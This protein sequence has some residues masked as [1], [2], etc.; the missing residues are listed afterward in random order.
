MESHEQRWLRLAARSRKTLIT[1]P[2]TT[3]TPLMSRR[4]KIHD[5]IIGVLLIA[6]TGLSIAVDPRFMWLAGITGMIMLS[7]SFTGF[8][9]VHYAVRR[10]L[11]DPTDQTAV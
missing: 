9:P 1:I 8:C 5:G 11:P 2:M 6:T 10:A 3:K 7:S 4:V